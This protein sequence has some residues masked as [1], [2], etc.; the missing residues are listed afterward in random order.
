[1]AKKK[2]SSWKHKH[3][4]DVDLLSK[5]EYKSIFTLADKYNKILND[6]KNIKKTLNNVNIFNVF[7]EPSTRTRASFEL[8]GK[9]LGANVIN[10]ASNVSASQ[11]GENLIKKADSSLFALTRFL[12]A[13]L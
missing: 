10:I 12:L 5:Y 6:K 7:Y 1:M 11:K 2:K 9:L 4:L 13:K 3:L 8:A